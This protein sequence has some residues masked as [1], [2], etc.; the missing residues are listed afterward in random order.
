M[1]RVLVVG[2]GFSG[3]A[4]AHFLRR[5]GAS[6]EVREAT[7]RA[8]GLLAT[9][10]RDGWLVEHGANGFVDSEPAAVELARDVGVPL[11]RAEPKGATRFVVVDKKLVQ[12]PTRPQQI[13]TSS[14]LSVAGKVR[15]L[16]EGQ[17]VPHRDEESVARFATRRFGAEAVDLADA[18]VTGIYAGDPQ[19]LSLDHAFPEVRRMEHEHGSVLRALRGRRTRGPKPA[20]SAPEG[21][22]S[23]L[24]DALAAEAAP[25]YNA[26]M[27]RIDF[28]EWDA[29]VV[30]LP[31]NAARALVGGEEAHW[32]S[33][34]AAKVA[35]VALGYPV[36]RAA[37]ATR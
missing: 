8:G 19:H 27:A 36:K 10:A 5:A 34:R 1:T 35:V 33:Q 7:G 11:V 18:M 25:T 30:A 20:L 12:V 2:A 15:F 9:T 37:A 24:I 22:M 28:A 3:L 4:A 23:A 14:L 17:V 13:L 31:P 16:R 29:V 26:R 6:V 21:G 32:P